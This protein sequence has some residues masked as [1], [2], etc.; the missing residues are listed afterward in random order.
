[1][2]KT[3]LKLNTITSIE[4]FIQLNS[5]MPFHIDVTSG[6]YIVDG[7]SIMGIFSID[8]SKPIDCILHTDDENIIGIYK[9]HLFLTSGIEVI[10]FDQK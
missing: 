9:E 1:M 3:T 5:G 2:I 8:T 10:S 7:K 6:R 4:K